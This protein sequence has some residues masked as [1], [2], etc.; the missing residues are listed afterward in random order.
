MPPTRE[1]AVLALKDVLGRGR[2]PKQVLEHLGQGM[3]RR[4]RAFLVELV[5]GVIR[6]RDLLDRV[7]A[8]L[9]EKPL[10][11]GTASLMNLRAGLYQILFMRVP[12]WAAVNETVAVE[13]QKRGLVNGVLRNVLRQRE[14]IRA[15]LDSLRT[16]AAGGEAR[17]IALWTSHP[18]WLIK[19]WCARLGPEEAFRLAEANNAPAFLTLRV[20]TLRATRQE[21]LRHLTALGIEG[22]AS[23]LSP[24]GIVLTGWHVFSEL[25]PLRGLVRVQDEAA[26]LV[27]IMLEP[28]PGE[29]VLDACAAPGG[30]TTHL[31]ELMQGRGEIVALDIEAPRL[32]LLRENL[33]DLDIR[34]VRVVQADVRSY[35]DAAGFHRVMLDAP[36][37]ALGTVRRNPDVKYRLRRGDLGRFGQRQLGLLQAAA[38]LVRPGGSILFCTCST[39]PEEGED[40]VRAFLKHAPDFAIIEDVPPV[41]T[42]MDGGFLRTYPHRHGTDG[43]FGARLTRHG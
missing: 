2:K 21:V 38:G 30:K 18:G 16:R 33:G 1:R 13:H 11:E 31:T 26:Q 6:H 19:R 35:R 27:S 39:E 5:Y 32:A 3:D 14:D 29:R 9:M 12:E 28:R 10:R 23:A 40:V 8:Q 22:R 41:R 43:F 36:C 15:D 37:S 17:A 7:L 34:N 4:D 24:E 25:E 42:V 20:N